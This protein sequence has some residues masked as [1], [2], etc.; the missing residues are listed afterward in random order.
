MAVS[1]NDIVGEARLSGFTRFYVAP[2]S[3]T[4]TM[5]D[6]IARVLRSEEPELW[7]FDIIDLPGQVK[8]AMGTDTFD[9]VTQD[10]VPLPSLRL[11]FGFS[12]PFGLEFLGHGFFLPA[13]LVDVGID[14][15]PT[16]DDIDIKGL[17]TRLE[18]LTLGGTLR[19]N[20]IAERE[21]SIRPALSVGAS[22]VYSSFTLAMDDFN[23]A[24]LGMELDSKDTGG[25]G[26]LDMS[27][28][29]GIEEWTHSF[30]LTMFLSKRVLWI[31]TPFVKTGVYYH[32]SN[33]SSNLAAV[34]TFTKEVDGKPS[35]DSKDIESMDITVPVDIGT[36]DV[37]LLFSGGIEFRIYP[38]TLQTCVTV[39]MERPVIEL[40]D[41]FRFNGVA[42]TVALRIQI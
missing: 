40:M 30:G 22:Y 21:G 15:A 41:G 5:Y 27:G 16:G 25:L 7:K 19:R 3:V 31:L 6:G 37:S 11:G 24:A 28:K 1:G 35:T 18:M 14:M 38:V 17:G 8:E 39:D 36:E 23:L 26:Y 2:L 29:F 34:A 4:A 10:M 20:L 32:V 12:L 13:A 9:M 33:Y 42:G